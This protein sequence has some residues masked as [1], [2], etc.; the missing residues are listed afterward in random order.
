M[1]DVADVARQPQALVSTPFR[2]CRCLCL[3]LPCFGLPVYNANVHPPTQAFPLLLDAV[4]CN[5]CFFF[6]SRSFGSCWIGKRDIFGF[7]Y[8]V[9]LSL[10][11]L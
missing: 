1:G 6:V 3:K 5:I 2:V 11:R 4:I 7:G 8:L 9:R 10:L